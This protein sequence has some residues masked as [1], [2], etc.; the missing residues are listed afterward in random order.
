MP[1]AESAP[2]WA[3]EIALAY[4]SGAHGQFILYGNVHDRLPAG[5]RLVN[6]ARYVEDELLAAFPVVFAY[7]LGNGLTVERGD[8]V[9]Q[10][11]GGAAELPQRPR[12]PLLAIDFISRYLR[13]LGNLRALGRGD[14]S[15]SVAVILRGVDQ[16]LPADGGGF[17]HGS[18]TSLVREWATEAPF[19]DL[20][21]ASILI[22]DN[23]NDVEP[24]VAFNARAARIGVP[25]PD[26]AA[27]GAGLTLLK[28]DAAPA[29]A[30]DADLAAMA[31]ALVGVTV[32]ALESLVKLRA[33]E[34]RTLSPTDWVEIKK[35]LVERDSG[36]L[37]EF[38]EPRR[39]LAD[40]HGQPALKAWLQEDIALWRA[41][42]LKALPK[43]YLIC[44]PV[45]TGKTFL[46]ECLA[47]DAGAPVVKLKNFRDR[48]VGSSEG[49][50]EKIFRL[51]RALGRC[52]VF[53]D[54]ADQTLGKRESDSGDGGLSG[55]L[56]SMIAQEMADSAN[57]GKIVWIL[58]S[59][60]PD[61][62]EV[63]LKRPGR[64][65]VKVPI[66]PTTT[67]AESA[68]L[69]GALGARYELVLT[70]ADLT[71][72]ESRL[73]V[74]LTPGAAEA[75]VVKAYRHAR[76]RNVAPAA[77]LAACLEGYQNPVP[78]DVLELQMRLAV[79]EATDLAF[80]PPAL[81]HFAGG[82]NGA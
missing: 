20:P 47:G 50:L 29:F 76:T 8:A 82:P 9:V 32:G 45:G 78:A 2:A 73:P 74:L 7:D 41:G 39:T 23:L 52:I 3:R 42:D 77:A 65:D 46:V 24:L 18:L 64:V 68:A 63:D 43:G 36:G 54:E 21:F 15:G 66:L 49:N 37:V 56:Y 81:R 34:R 62:I 53:I 13:Y 59:S 26:A 12:E 31:A 51:V 35:N 4:E 80:V 69:L 16:I 25:L 33:H 1:A 5:D 22:A 72:L 70:P 75:L 60:R 67:A 11:W 17:V 79:R 19:C 57:R 10:E 71:A 61:L 6:L 55:R 58:A 14:G 40:Y 30:A 38:V 28:R 48:W 27:L 44:G